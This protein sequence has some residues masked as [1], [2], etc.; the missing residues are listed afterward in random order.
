MI[1]ILL[2]IFF[3][4]CSPKKDQADNEL[5]IFAAASLTN[6]F[7]ELGARFEELYPDT[8]IL[9]NFGSS[10]QLAAQILSGVYCDIYASANENQMD[11][12]QEAGAI[13]GEIS[14]FATNT[15]VIGIPEGN[16]L[17]ITDLNDLTQPNL[18]L[19]L[20]VSDTPIREYSDQIVLN[21]LT[22]S[23]QIQFFEN[24]VSEE[25]NVRQVVTKIALGEADA[26]LVYATDITPD[27]APLV[28]RISIPPENNI[29]ARYPIAL[30]DRSVNIDIGIKFIEYLKSEDGQNILLNWG[31]GSIP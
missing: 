28:D 25:P 13:K 7:E 31:F 30:L 10:S 22:P 14:I 1:L 2:G 8:D 23:K 12:I 15:L 18:R 11:L 16:P 3:S 29:I 20:A 27:V 21:Y 17:G 4:G 26:S 9:F 24:V 6:A 5:V 19:V